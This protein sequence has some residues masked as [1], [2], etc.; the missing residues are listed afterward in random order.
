MK[1]LMQWKKEKS[2]YGSLTYDMDHHK[3]E[4]FVA[5]CHSSCYSKCTQKHAP[6]NHNGMF[7][8][9]EPCKGGSH[10]N[11]KVKGMDVDTQAPSPEINI[12]HVKVA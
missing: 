5:P 9:S 11:D 3:N 7:S 10:L 8:W 12:M 1:E 2:N 6:W 4:Y